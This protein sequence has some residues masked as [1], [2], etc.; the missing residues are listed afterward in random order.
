MEDFSVQQ[1]IE[2]LIR[3][4]EEQIKHLSSTHEL[5]MKQLKEQS[6]INILNLKVQ[7]DKQINLVNVSHKA[8]VC[9][10]EEEI[11]YLRE[12]NS[13]QRFMMEHY[14]ISIKDLEDKLSDLSGNP[15]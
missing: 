8:Q 7:F 10:L 13:S 6:D 9:K 15:S 12:M 2:S 1:K 4:L 3:Q 5:D 11:N 14:L